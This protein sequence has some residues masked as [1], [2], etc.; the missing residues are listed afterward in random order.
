MR[1]IYIPGAELNE[2]FCNHTVV[3]LRWWLLCRGITSLALQDPLR[4]GAYRLEIISAVLR[5][6]GTFHSTKNIRANSFCWVLI[7]SRVHSCAL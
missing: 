6:S 7:R 2:P 3:S 1:Y 5:G 4:T